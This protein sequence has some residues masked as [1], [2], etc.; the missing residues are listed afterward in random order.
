MTA[1]MKRIIVI[2]EGPTEKEFCTDVL[3]PHLTPRNI[4]LELPLIKKSGGGIVAWPVLKKQIETH[5]KSDPTAV[6]TTLIDY[7]G[8][9]Q[10]HEYPAW[11]V[12][13][14]NVNKSERMDLL[15]SAMASE[16]DDKYSFRFIPYIQLH[17]FE[18]LLFTDLTVFDQNFTPAEFKDK[19]GFDHIF[20]T[21]ANPEDINNNPHSAPSKR[22]L[23]HIVGY[24]K[25]VYGSL[26]AYSAGLKQI[27]AK[28]P[29]FNH[30]VSILES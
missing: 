11:D 6:V 8:I 16:I 7:Y 15:E 2:C 30:W 22:L 12:A 28:C 20:F 25:V 9:Y 5:L 26:L 17:E 21:H 10:K 13:H 3:Q 24:N 29:R 19:P 23:H 1:P 27:R 18:G 14:L 4:F